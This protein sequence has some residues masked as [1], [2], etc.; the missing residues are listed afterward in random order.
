MSLTNFPYDDD[1]EDQEKI[2]HSK[3]Y[4]NI[5]V[6][7][8]NV[9]YIETYP[10]FLVSYKFKDG[11]RQDLDCLSHNGILMNLCGYIDLPMLLYNQG[12]SVF[13]C[14]ITYDLFEFWIKILTFQ[15]NPKKK[16]ICFDSSLLKLKTRTGNFIPGYFLCI[17]DKLTNDDVYTENLYF[18]FQQ[19]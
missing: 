17:K 1:L 18:V 19:E 6:E 12:F 9:D 7:V 3:I 14:L 10:F 16:I 4:S 8:N 15:L 2:E 13:N 11:K 5:P